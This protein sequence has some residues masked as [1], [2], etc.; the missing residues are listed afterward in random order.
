MISAQPA[1][2][3]AVTRDAVYYTKVRIAVTF[4]D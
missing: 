1:Y 4:S 3:V 2:K